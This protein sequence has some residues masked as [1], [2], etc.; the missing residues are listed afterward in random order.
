MSVRMGR[1]AERFDPKRTPVYKKAV[2][3]AKEKY[4]GMSD[5]EKRQAHQAMALNDM[6]L[7]GMPTFYGK[8]PSRAMGPVRE[9][10]ACSCGGC[11]A[12]RD[13]YICP[14]CGKQIPKGYHKHFSC[15]WIDQAIEQG[16]AGGRS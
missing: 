13:G 5:V 1:T 10:R 3:I 2:A 16:N 4:D 12:A 11:C 14:R 8:L 7:P 6:N 15:G 9:A